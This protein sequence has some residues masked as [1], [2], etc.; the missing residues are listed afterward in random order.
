MTAA[1]VALGLFGKASITCSYAM[2]YLYSSEVYPT[3]M[4][5]IG[6]GGGAMMARLGGVVAPFAAELVRVVVVLFVVVVCVLISSVKF[7]SPCFISDDIYFR[8]YRLS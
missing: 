8:I 2:V 4:R 5:G 7:Y 1:R 3:V 6:V